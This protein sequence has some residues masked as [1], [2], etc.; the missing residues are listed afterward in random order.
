M[1]TRHVKWIISVFSAM[2]VITACLP[3]LVVDELKISPSHPTTV[4]RINGV[5]VVK[6]WSLWRA[7]SS[8]HAEI[9]IRKRN[10]LPP[11]FLLVL[12]SQQ[13]DVPSLEGFISHQL[14]FSKKLENP[15][16][17]TATAK[18]DASHR[19][20]ES[21]E[22]NNSKTIEFFV[23]EIPK[24]IDK[25]YIELEK[26]ERI[27]KFRSAVG[28]DASDDF[29][30]C[31]SMK[32]YF[33]PYENLAWCAVQIFSPINGTV[34]GI[35][36]QSAGGTKVRITSAAYPTFAVSIYHIHLTHPLNVGDSVVADQP[37][38]THIGPGTMSDIEVSLEKPDGVKRISYFDV[39]TD[40]LFENYQARGLNSRQDAIISREARDADPLTCTATGFVGSGSLE[41]WVTF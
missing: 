16:K 33:Q 38:G 2:F 19:V 17:Y 26:I 37:L 21:N 18:A 6:N 15:G 5:A 22:E 40:S 27:S 3:D 13:F 23:L 24:F 31:R 35:Y 30:S 7:A 8:S 20:P 36:P 4:D 34:S 28:H 12:Y 10:P 39:M 41:N 1:L 32:H 9:K 11:P 25:D 29:E 14:T